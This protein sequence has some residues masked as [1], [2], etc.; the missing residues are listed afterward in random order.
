MGATLVFYLAMLAVGFA[1]QLFDGTLGMGY[2]VTSATLLISLGVYPVLAS[3]SVHMAEVVVTLASGMS[4]FRMRNVKR[5]T[6][7]HW[8]S[9]E[10][11][12]ESWGPM[13]WSTSLCV[14]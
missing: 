3:A 2:G 7:F 8:Q 5:N 14:R 10:L 4:H 13:V 6:F 1:A 11:L 12:G 9:A